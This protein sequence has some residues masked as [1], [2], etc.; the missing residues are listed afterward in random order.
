MII[1]RNFFFAML[2]ILP[3]GPLLGPRLFW[4]ARSERGWGVMAFKGGGNAGEQMPL[5]YSVIYFRHGKDTVWFNGLGSLGVSDGAIIPI[6]YQIDKPENARVDI[7]QAIW[8]DILVYE[9]IPVL[10][11]LFIYADP[12]VIPYRK[13]VWLNWRR[14][15]I[16]IV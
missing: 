11:L 12:V 9:G 13:K 8:G 15:F 3:V 2:A 7:W 14:P 10:M 6:R 4:L 5:S 16:R 1:S